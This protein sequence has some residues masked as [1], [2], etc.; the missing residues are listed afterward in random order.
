M[1]DEVEV[2]QVIKTTLTR[3]GA[4]VPDDPIRVVTEYWSMKGEKLCEVDPCM[5]SVQKRMPEPLLK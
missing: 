1:M 3:R 5:V 2:M 4:G